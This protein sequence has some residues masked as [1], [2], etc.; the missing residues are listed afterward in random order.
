VQL[1]G[2]TATLRAFWLVSEGRLALSPTGVYKTEWMSELSKSEP[3]LRIS[4][5]WKSAVVSI[6]MAAFL[7]IDASLFSVKS[8]H[9]IQYASLSFGPIVLVILTIR[10]ARVAIVLRDQQIELRRLAWTKRIAFSDV[11][12]ID[13]GSEITPIARYY[14]VFAPNDGRVIKMKDVFLW[15]TTKNAMSRVE[16]WSRTVKE[17]IAT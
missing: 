4:V 12:S 9:A 17:S 15:G 14:L 11:K 6:S 16:E 13:V 3:I 1:Y 2:V 8:I 10:A 5:R 7:L